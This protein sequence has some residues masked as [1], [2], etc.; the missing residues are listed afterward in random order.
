MPPPVKDEYLKNATD[1]QMNKIYSIED[2]IIS[3]KN[4]KDKIEKKYKITK[5]EHN[6]SIKT[7]KMLKTQNSQL[8]EKQKL[9]IEMEDQEKISA[10]E[11]ELKENDRLLNN[12][13]INSEYLD[14]KS[15]YEKSLL[16][17]AYAKLSLKVSERSY[18]RAKIA[19]A[20]QE[21]VL[22]EQKPEETAEAKEGEK[23][24]KEDLLDLEKYNKYYEKQKEILK[25]QQ[26][27]KNRAAEKLG[28][29]ELKLDD[30]KK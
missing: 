1:Q 13:I 29:A 19:R 6:V 14:A 4:E 28:Q 21:Q 17:V 12:E 16:E 27:T 20:Y 18:E 22:D 9:F 8:K 30:I 15:K 24:K 5:Q 11:K 7:I 26:G 3:I 10:G 25:K 23:Q 2:E